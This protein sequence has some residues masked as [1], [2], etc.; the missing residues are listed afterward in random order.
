MFCMIQ[1]NVHAVDA[2]IRSLKTVKG[3][4]LSVNAEFF[5]KE[6]ADSPECQQERYTGT[7]V[8]EIGQGEKRPG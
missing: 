5:G 7:M 6:W 4:K 1:V 3:V 8:G 2:I